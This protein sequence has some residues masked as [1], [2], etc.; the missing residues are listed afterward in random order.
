M[1]PITHLLV[2]W[3]LADNGA[4]VPRD[5]SRITWAGVLPDL[6]GLGAVADVGQ[7]LLGGS[8]SW[9]Y[10][11]WHHRLLHGLPGAIVLP[12]TLA[13]GATRPLRVFALGF[14]AVHLHLLCDLVGS[15]G[16]AESDLWPIWYLAPFSDV[17]ELVWQGQWPLNAWPNVLFTLILL[18]YALWAAVIRGY[19]VVGVV[20]SKADAR[21]VS[22][23]RSRWRTRSTP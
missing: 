4:D 19:S 12:A 6:D 16:P 1:S 14:V 5:R 13:I 8:G 21:V 23:L 22:T 7:T 11:D 18:A 2:S 20:S 9:H 3:T 17:P 10:A 15:R